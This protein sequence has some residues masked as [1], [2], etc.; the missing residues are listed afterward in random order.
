MTPSQGSRLHE[1]PD[2]TDV[3]IVGGGPVGL[4]LAA[5]L[6]QD[7][8]KTTVFERREAPFTEP[9]A[10][11]FDPETLRTF[12]RIGRLDAVAPTLETDVP[13]GYYDGGGRLLARVTSMEKRFGFSPRGTFYQPELEEAIAGGLSAHPSLS[14]YRGVT[15]GD[16]ADLGGR[17]R[18]CVSG[19]D[20]AVRR[21]DARYVVACDGGTSRVRE[22]LGIAFEGSTFPEKWLVVDVQDD[23]YPHR[24]IRFFCDPKRPAVTLP[25][26]KG[27][28]RWEFLLLPG[29]DEARFADHDHARALILGRAGSAP[30]HIERSLVYTFHARI[31]EHFRAGR[32]FL[33]GDAAHLTPPFAGQG[34]NGGIRDA[35]NLAWKLAAVCGGR[36][37]EAILDTY[38]AERRA[39]THAM[40][41]LA[42][43]LGGAIMP[44]SRLRALVRDL[45]MRTLWAIPSLRTRLERGDVIPAPSI[46]KSSLVNW[47]AAGPVGQMIPQP[48]IRTPAGEVMLDELLGSGFSLIGVGV[49]PWELLTEADRKVA[50]ALRARIVHLHPEGDGEDAASELSRW[51][52]VEEGVLVVRPDRFLVDR[53]VRSRP[54]E[55]LAWMRAAY[56]IPPAPALE[57]QPERAAA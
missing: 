51:A 53:I 56:H 45:V 50:D 8:V 35:A 55:K 46:E 9:R 7:G 28:R 15:V 1:L 25:V 40:T 33:A 32:I 39:H 11:A 10:I 19:A 27:R 42:V 21:I 48:L 2:S 13:V 22:R 38:D 52:G 37:G 44:T 14:I 30:R 47:A 57:H 18:L 31:A 20:G 23:D 43:R 5:L 4:M 3:A 54:G 17:V 24:E 29:D 34:L 49:D 41:A 12:Q 16:V 6:A 26:S 36:M